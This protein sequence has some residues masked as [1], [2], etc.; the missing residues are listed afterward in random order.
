MHMHIFNSIPNIP[1]TSLYL[2]IHIQILHG[3]GPGRLG[4]G[5][6]VGWV[7]GGSGPRPGAQGP[8]PCKVYVCMY[9][10]YV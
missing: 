5:G 2:Y 3:P 8:G 4:W 7:R 9:D 1:N 10:M 6:E